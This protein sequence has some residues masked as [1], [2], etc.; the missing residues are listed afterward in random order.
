V[1]K[2]DAVRFVIPTHFLRLTEP[3]NARLVILLPIFSHSEVNH[4]ARITRA[5]KLVPIW[6]ELAMI[7][8][9]TV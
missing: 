4:L 2:I 1:A 8:A 6:L 5:G 3:P 9:P 7:V